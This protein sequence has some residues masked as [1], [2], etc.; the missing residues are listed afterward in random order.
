[1]EVL[2]T[3]GAELSGATI[4]GKALLVTGAQAQGHAVF[5]F[6]ATLFSGQTRTIVLQL[7]E[8][9]TQGSV[10]LMEPQ[11]LVRPMAQRASLQ[12]CRVSAK[13]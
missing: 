4:D 10:E 13:R 5:A 1:V 7:T 6:N 8:P 3:N 12:A 9:P 2:A 11:P